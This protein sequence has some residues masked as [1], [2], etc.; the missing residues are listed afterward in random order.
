MK[1]EW[2]TQP[3]KGTILKANYNLKARKVLT[4]YGVLNLTKVQF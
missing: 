3:Y 1:I 4:L 2:C